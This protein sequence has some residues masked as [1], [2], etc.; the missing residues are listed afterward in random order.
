MVER[1]ERVCRLVLAVARDFEQR[2][3]AGGDFKRS[4]KAR[5]FF[6]WLRDTEERRF[7]YELERRHAE[8]WGRCLQRF[9]S[10]LDS[11]PFR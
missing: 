10:G 1:H 4:G 9:L 3:K 6:A 2:M 5:E 8:I 7:T 11:H